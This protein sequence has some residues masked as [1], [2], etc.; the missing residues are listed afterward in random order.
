MKAGRRT[1]PAFLLSG[2]DSELNSRADAGV[3][4]GLKQNSPSE[5]QRPELQEFLQFENQCL[6]CESQLE[7]RIEKDLSDHEIEES[8]H[9]PQCDLRVRLKTHNLH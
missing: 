5:S 6:L 8:A 7:V 3:T 9:C 4:S 2:I 1:F